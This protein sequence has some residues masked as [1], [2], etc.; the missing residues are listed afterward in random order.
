LELWLRRTIATGRWLRIREAS[1]FRPYTLIT[2][3]LIIR[4]MIAAYNGYLGADVGLEADA[5]AFY[6]EMSFI[7]ATGQF[8]PLSVGPST[9][10]N[11][12]GMLMG[13]M[14]SSVFVAS[15]PGCLAWWLSGHLFIASARLI[16]ADARQ[17]S[18]FAFLFAFWPTAIPYSS[19]PLRESFQ[20]CFVAL[21]TWGALQIVLNQRHTGWIWV[22][23]GIMMAG[24]QHGSLLAFG[25][26][27]IGV[28]FIISAM[29]GGHQFPWAK[30]LI[31]LIPTTMLVYFGFS[32]F[33]SISYDL[34]GGAFEAIE[35]YNR[36]GEISRSTYKQFASS[37]GVVSRVL[38]LT[39]GFFQYLF[40][41][42]PQRISTIGDIILT[43]ENIIRG[44]VIMACFFRYRR[45]DVRD[46]KLVLLLLGLLY[47]IQEGIWS[48][49][50]ANWGTASRHHVPAMGLMLLTAIKAGVLSQT[51]VNK[52][53]RTVRPFQATFTRRSE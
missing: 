45:L 27:F 30:F 28:L 14:G 39:M 15:L 9:L 31:G 17:L 47:I 41:P 49:G 44:V 12:V 24:S 32:L 23:S 37:D 34:S 11:A 53:I 46:D 38:F 35:N 3:G 2:I 8:L 52:Q 42:L 4:L 5:R 19:G 18:W 50:T 20:L 25:I 43:F 7:A 13:I 33:S 16:K 29:I 1:V 26:L 22:I 21:A 36:G 40:E 6:D 10:I 48:V 51:D